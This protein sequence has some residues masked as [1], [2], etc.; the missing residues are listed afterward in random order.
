MKRQRRNFT[1]QFK[2]EIV[3]AILNDKMTR[4][5][6]SNQHAISLPLLDRWVNDY[7]ASDKMHD[8]LQPVFKER[9]K[10]YA[11]TQEL[12]AKIAE[13][14][15]RIEQMNRGNVTWTPPMRAEAHNRNT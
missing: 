2:Q 9:R 15:M 4:K 8:S 6:I 1:K 13:L 3:K 14:Y 7:L 10:D 5:E 11:T 12:K